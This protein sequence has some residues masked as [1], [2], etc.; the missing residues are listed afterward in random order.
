MRSGTAAFLNVTATMYRATPGTV[1]VE[2]S[3]TAWQATSL[4][5]VKSR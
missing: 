5:L 2:V 4:P 1:C 3:G